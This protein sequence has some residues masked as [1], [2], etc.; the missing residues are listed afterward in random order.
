M[1]HLW[2]NIPVKLTGHSVGFFP[3]AM[4]SPLEQLSSRERA[5]LVSFLLRSLEP[6][7]DVEVEAAWEAELARRVTDIQRGKVVGN[8]TLKAGKIER[9]HLSTEAP[10]VM[11]LLLEGPTPDFMLGRIFEA[12]Q[13]SALE[14]V[15]KTGQNFNSEEILETIAKDKF[16]KLNCQLIGK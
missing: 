11:L 9:E 12:A 7:E 3:F 4:W 6:E 13:Q 1:P 2:P 15:Y 16:W 14:E 8:S 5:K 10:T